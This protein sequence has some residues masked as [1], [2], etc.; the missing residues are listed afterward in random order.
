MTPLCGTKPCSILT[1]VR[2]VRG[3]AMAPGAALGLVVVRRAARGEMHTPEEWEAMRGI[4]TRLYL[5]D[6]RSLPEMIEILARDYRFI[7]K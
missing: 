5:S 7:A 4:I 2:T 6:R 3:I 1:T